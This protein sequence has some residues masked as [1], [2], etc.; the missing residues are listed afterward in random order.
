MSGY[1]DIPCITWG[2]MGHLVVDRQ[3]RH[4][5]KMKYV[6]IGKTQAKHMLFTLRDV[7]TADLFTALATA[8]VPIPWSGHVAT[9]VA[10]QLEKLI[11]LR[12]AATEPTL[13][14]NGL[15]LTIADLE[16][17]VAMAYRLGDQRWTPDAGVSSDG[18]DL[19]IT[20]NVSLS[21]IVERLVNFARVHAEVD[22]A[23]PAE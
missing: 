23:E 21:V 18:D 15:W 19:P 22:V 14:K 4:A 16:G 10:L 13:L 5:M 3:L 11:A 7:F 2:S 12:A 6:S 20:T 9:L 1:L 8:W 17:S